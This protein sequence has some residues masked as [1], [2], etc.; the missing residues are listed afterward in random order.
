[1]NIECL[2]KDNG[3]TPTKQRLEI[4]E[5]IFAKNQHFT[6]AQ[7]IEKVGDI[8]LPISQATIYN[9]LCLFESTG[10]LKTI[11]LRNDCKFYDTNLRSHHHI[12]NTSNNT[13]V[14]VSDDKIAFSKM[15]D[16]PSDLELEQTEVL[17]KVRNK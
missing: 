3:I 5:L 17:I 8:K 16:I 15:P 13:L 14:D 11:D 9:T 12:Y 2:L 4:A 1:M 6:A 7:L 10:L